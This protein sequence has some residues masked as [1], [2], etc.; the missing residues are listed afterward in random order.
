M[1]LSL[2]YAEIVSLASVGQAACAVRS[3]T[4]ILECVR[5]TVTG[6]EVEAIASDRFVIGRVTF[7]LAVYPELG[8][9]PITYLVNAQA[10]A[11]AATSAKRAGKGW[12]G[13]GAALVT[14]DATEGGV[15]LS[16]A[17][18]DTFRSATPGGNFPPVEKLAEGDWNA[19][20]PSGQAINVLAL[21]QLA[22][23]RH[24]LDTLTGAGA[25]HFGGFNVARRLDQASPA[26]LAPWSLSR[27]D[28]AVFAM[29]QPL[30]KLSNA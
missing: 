23:L 8:D 21:A 11:Q 12:H 25:T 30:L 9:E 27:R 28:G 13:T 14:L 24:P 15:T 3:N 10:L 22:K 19:D 20:I 6:R 26:K 5:I 18:G 4:P 7:T 16:L 2:N 29:I 17:T 1:S